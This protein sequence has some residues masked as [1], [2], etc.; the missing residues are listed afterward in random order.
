MP[1]LARRRSPD[2]TDECWHVYF[3]DV[4]IGTIAMRTGA[5]HDEDPWGWNCGFYP[6]SHP[7]ECTDGQV[8]SSPRRFRSCLASVSVKAHKGRFSEV[9]RSAGLDGREISSLRS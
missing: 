9:A 8:R 3:G 5:P 2:A 4:H 6:G 1:A 7:R